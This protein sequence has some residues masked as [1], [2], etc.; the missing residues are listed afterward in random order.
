MRPRGGCGWNRRAIRIASISTAPADQPQGHGDPYGSGQPGIAASVFGGPQVKILSFEGGNLSAGSPDT[1][2]PV[3]SN[4]QPAGVLAWGTTQTTV[5]LT[6]NEAA[7]CRYSTQAGVAYSAM[8]DHV[9]DDGRDG[10]YDRG[11]RADQRQ[12]LHLL[13]P[14]RG[15]AGQCEHGRLRHRLRRRECRR[16]PRAPSLA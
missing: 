5:S 13:R 3:R 1:A 14:L 12:Q 2:P 4:G 10:P 15:C 7:T 6:T 16:R 11:Q 8:S 9:H